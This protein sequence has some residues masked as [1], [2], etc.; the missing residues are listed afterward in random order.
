DPASKKLVET[1]R[2]SDQDL[3]IDY[4]A[5]I[6]ETYFYQQDLLAIFENI[7]DQISEVYRRELSYLEE[8][9]IVLIAH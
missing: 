3:C 1:S 9:K 4:F 6:L 5:I 2:V 8:I 7:K